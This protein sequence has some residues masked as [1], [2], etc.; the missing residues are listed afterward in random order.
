TPSHRHR[1]RAVRSA[2]GVV[3]CDLRL[4][5]GV[6]TNPSNADLACLYATSPPA[7]SPRGGGAQPGAPRPAH[8]AELRVRAAD[9]RAAR[10]GGSAAADVRARGRR[11][12]RRGH[13]RLLGAARRIGQAAVD[14]R[15]GSRRRQTDDRAP[16]PTAA[17]VRPVG[18]VRRA[19]DAR[20][21]ALLAVRA[22]R[23]LRHLALSLDRA[24]TRT[25]APDPRRAAPP[26]GG[27]RWR[28]ESRE[29]AASAHALRRRGVTRRWRR[30]TSCKRTRTILC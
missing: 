3:S 27:A 20:R 5:L 9:R 24:R 22:P 15:G 13:A 12:S 28:A 17:A 19:D 23:T 16:R 8:S 11:G 30:A 18:V 21:A 26:G 1:A 4:L 6:H 29:R 25:R 10:G 2:A 14:A 7:C